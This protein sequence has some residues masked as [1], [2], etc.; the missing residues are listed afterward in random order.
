MVQVN[1]SASG[2]FVPEET[3]NHN[4]QLSLYHVKLKKKNCISRKGVNLVPNAVSVWLRKRYISV[5]VNTG[6][7][8]NITL[9]QNKLFKG[10]ASTKRK[11][12]KYKKQ[13]NLNCSLHTKKSS[14]SNANKLTQVIQYHLLSSFIRINIRTIKY[15]SASICQH[16]I[17]III[18]IILIKNNIIIFQSHC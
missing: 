4:L 12:K 9:V 1:F 10:L 17:I 6:A 15:M 3:N 18:I 14:K 5:L 8:Y 2:F 13:K 11:T 7:P 16:N